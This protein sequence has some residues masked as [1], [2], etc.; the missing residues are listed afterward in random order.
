MVWLLLLINLLAL[1]TEAP[2]LIKDHMYR[3]LGVFM[4]FFAIGLYFSLA[5]YFHWPLQE[6]FNALVSY[7]YIPMQQ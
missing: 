2:F 4:V 6:P 1:L 7:M 5:F 3:E